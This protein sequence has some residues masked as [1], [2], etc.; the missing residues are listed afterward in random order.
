MLAER[1]QEFE[2]NGR[3]FGRKTAAPAVQDLRS[4]G[5]L[6]VDNYSVFVNGTK[7]KFPKGLGA[8][9][10]PDDN[11]GVCCAYVPVLEAL[12]AS[13]AAVECLNLVLG[14]DPTEGLVV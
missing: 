2:P 7:V 11:T 4:D 6:A 14:A 3:T 1:Q 13:G 12:K 9:V 8:P 10:K 5:A